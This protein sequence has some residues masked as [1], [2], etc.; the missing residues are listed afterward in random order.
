MLMLNF[1]HPLSPAQ[2]ARVEML[3]GESV[4]VRTIATQFN[5]YEPF[6]QQA[7]ALADAACLTAEEWQMLPLLVNLPGY[8][9]GAGCLLAEIHGRSGHFPALLRLSP[10]D[11]NLPT[12]YVVSEVVNLQDVRERARIR[13]H[14]KR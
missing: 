12:V 3:V 11:G 1:S 6:A 2:V 7:A 14:G 9:P 5:H 4:G 13:R 10:K 8:A